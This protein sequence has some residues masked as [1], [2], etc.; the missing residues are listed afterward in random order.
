MRKQSSIGII[1]VICFLTPFFLGGCTD[2]VTDQTSRPIH[3]SAE[4]TTKDP[5]LNDRIVVQSEGRYVIA[6][7]DGKILWKVDVIAAA[8]GPIAGIDSVRSLSVVG[9]EVRTVI[10]KHTHVVLDLATGSVLSAESD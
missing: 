4:V 5:A 9:N 8:P 3:D 10:G 6:R 2:A 1:L 7:R